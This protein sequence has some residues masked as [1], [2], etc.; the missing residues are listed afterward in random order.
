VSEPEQRLLSIAG[1]QQVDDAALA[2]EGY[3][4]MVGRLTGHNVSASVAFKL[5]VSTGPQIAGERQ[6]PAAY[7]FRFG[8]RLPDVG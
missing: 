6:E 2:A 5:E 3:Q 7:A 4:Q 8:D 1:E